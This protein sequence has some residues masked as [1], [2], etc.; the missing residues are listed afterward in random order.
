MDVAA[1]HGY[2]I[3][4]RAYW[5]KHC[6]EIR[7]WDVWAYDPAKNGPLP[8]IVGSGSTALEAIYAWKWLHGVP[9]S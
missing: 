7:G 4:V 9:E 6:P 1:G 5:P 3:E 8:Y 2:S